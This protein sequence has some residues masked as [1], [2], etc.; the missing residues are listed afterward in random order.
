MQCE[1]DVSIFD[2]CVRF[3]ATKGATFIE[4]GKAPFFG[5]KCCLKNNPLSP[6][7]PAVKGFACIITAGILASLDFCNYRKKADRK[8]A[9]DPFWI[10]PIPNI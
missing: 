1:N 3:E 9:S 6:S 10:H 7:L 4:L 8:T 2:N 5:E